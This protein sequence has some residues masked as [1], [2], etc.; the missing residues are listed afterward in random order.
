MAEEREVVARLKVERTGDKGAFTDAA[1]EVRELDAA[2]AESTGGLDDL[3]ES[4]STA[5]DAAGELGDKATGAGQAASSAA[6]PVASLGDAAEETGKKATTSREQLEEMFLKV[7][8]ALPVLHEAER[9]LQG[10]EGVLNDLGKA[11]GGTGHEFDGLGSKFGAFTASITQFFD[12]IGNIDDAFAA[13]SKTNGSLIERLD[14]AKQALDGLSPSAQKL[15]DTIAGTDEKLQAQADA[16]SEVITQTENA[17]EV[18]EKEA[19]RIGAALSKLAEK[20]K[21]SGVDLGTSFDELLNK[22]PALDEASAGRAK[23]VDS[24][25]KAAKASADEQ[26]DAL[27]LIKDAADPA[28]E[29][30]GSAATGV[31]TLGEAAGTASTGVTTLATG[32]TS[33]PEAAAGLGTAFESL[34][35]ISLESLLAQI[36][37]VRSELQGAAADAATLQ[38]AIAA[39]DAGSGGAAA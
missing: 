25:A 1:G 21:E 13:F 11:A 9:A 16:W 2:A 10:V 14:A 12:K 3:A 33:L 30:V 29:G 35:G 4:T 17:G 5:A 27:N 7:G 34:N 19:G 36:A 20:A 15:K 32:L 8:T 18:N 39:A 26:V 23:A 38:A 24:E 6:G 22:Y 37:T 28:A 31:G